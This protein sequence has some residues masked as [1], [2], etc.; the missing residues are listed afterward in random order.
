MGSGLWSIQVKSRRRMEDTVAEAEAEEQNCE[1]LML[2]GFPAPSVTCDSQLT[3]LN[4]EP[5]DLADEAQ[6]QVL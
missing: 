1:L 2:R 5:S 4:K 3:H 6:L